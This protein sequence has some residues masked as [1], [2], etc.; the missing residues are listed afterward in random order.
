MIYKMDLAE[1]E[2]LEKALAELDQRQAALNTERSLTIASN[3]EYS[4]YLVDYELYGGD[5]TPLGPIAFFQ[6]MEEI[7]AI[8]AKYKAAYKAG[9]TFEKLDKEYGL[10]LQQLERMLAV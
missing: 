10:R 7:T 2:R 9:E 8:Q 6:A 1:A 3:E 4:R 5:T